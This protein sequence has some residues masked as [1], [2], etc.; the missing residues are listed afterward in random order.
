MSSYKLDVKRDNKEKHREFFFNEVEKLDQLY[1][2]EDSK[3]TYHQFMKTVNLKE[4]KSCER[5]NVD[6]R[7]IAIDS[8]QWSM[9]KILYT[10]RHVKGLGA[11]FV[12][13]AFFNSDS[14]CE[15]IC[16]Q[17]RFEWAHYGIFINRYDILVF[18]DNQ[19]ITSDLPLNLVWFDGMSAWYNRYENRC[20]SA[21]QFFNMLTSDNL[22][23]KY[24]SQEC[25]IMVTI[26]I[27]RKNSRKPYKEMVQT[28][29]IDKSGGCIFTPMKFEPYNDVK[30]KM[31]LGQCVVKN[32]PDVPINVCQTSESD[33]IEI[34]SITRPD[35]KRRFDDLSTSND[36]IENDS[37][38]ESEG[39]DTEFDESSDNSDDWS[40]SDVSEESL[41]IDDDKFRA[42]V[43]E[44]MKNKKVHTTRLQV[45]TKK[46]QRIEFRIQEHQ[47]LLKELR[48]VEKCMNNIE[49][50]ISA[51]SVVK[52]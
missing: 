40:E 29:W 24:L 16:S 6:V 20:S 44:V 27:S 11:N 43:E 4:W 37:G 22:R 5:K 38:S 49:D 12:H 13:V 30:Q 9:A 26:H 47:R 21:S 18:L 42:D 32:N 34:V 10:K 15:K 14:D 19:N 31:A 33:E 28:D 39:E 41:Y 8:P 1:G 3:T 7:A 25:K 23:F 52:K 50:I 51:D 36:L 48:R 46:L 17:M 45:Q 35:K 2:A